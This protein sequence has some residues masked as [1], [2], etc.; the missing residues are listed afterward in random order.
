LRIP[1]GNK[2]VAMKLGARYRDG[3]WFA[4]AGID[5]S[6]FTERGWL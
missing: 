1:Y 3:G 4:P 2:E 6:P 5:L